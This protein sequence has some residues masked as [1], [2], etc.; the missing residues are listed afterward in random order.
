MSCGSQ[1]VEAK[2]FGLAALSLNATL[3]LYCQNHDPGLQNDLLDAVEEALAPEPGEAV[4]T[5]GGLVARCWIDGDIE[6]DEGLLGEQ[7][8]AIVPVSILIP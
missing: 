8:V 4:L 5:L 7:A 6:T 2:G 3:Y 1:S